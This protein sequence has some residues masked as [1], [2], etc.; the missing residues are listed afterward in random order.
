[1]LVPIIGSIQDEREEDRCSKGKDSISGG[2]GSS[3][4]SNSEGNHRQYLSDIEEKLTLERDSDTFI[5]IEIKSP[6]DDGMISCSSSSRS[7]HHD[8][9]EKGRHHSPSHSTEAHEI[10]LEEQC[11]GKIGIQ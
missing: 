4:S 8:Q 5:P 3:S 6:E 11:G 9:A 7:S 10:D 1:M 2:G